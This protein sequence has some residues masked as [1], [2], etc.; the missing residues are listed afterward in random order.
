M[1]VHTHRISSGDLATEL[2]VAFAAFRRQRAGTSVLVLPEDARPHVELVVLVVEELEASPEVG[3]LVLVHPSPS[4]GFLASAI[5]LRAGRARVSSCATV[6]AAVGEPRASRPP[7]GRF[8]TVILSAGQDLALALAPRLLGMRERGI[9]G[10]A[11]VL[12]KEAR[13]SSLL[14][15]VFCELMEVNSQLNALALVHPSPSLG[16]IASAIGLRLPQVKVMAFRDERELATSAF[17][18]RA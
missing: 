13:P 3:R 2:R 12:P 6:D 8:E 10:C 14:V 5:G 7:V 9:S 16:F 18:F 11:V 4:L 15:D 17:S 1:S